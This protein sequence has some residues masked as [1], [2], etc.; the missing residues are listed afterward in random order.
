MKIEVIIGRRHGQ[1][2]FE[3]LG[4]V[5]KAGGSNRATFKTFQRSNVHKEFSEVQL[6]ELVPVKR[7]RLDKPPTVQAATKPAPKQT[8]PLNA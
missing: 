6:C 3:P 1:E 8:K 5:D 7:R 2:K 4:P